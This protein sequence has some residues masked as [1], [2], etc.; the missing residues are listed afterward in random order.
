MK[1]TQITYGKTINI[2]NYQ[3]VRVD[4]TVD[5]REQDGDT[6][7][8]CLASL[9]YLVRNAEIDILRENQPTKR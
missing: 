3:S 5:V 2:G 4:F 9:K 8:S 7:E 1:I 6:E